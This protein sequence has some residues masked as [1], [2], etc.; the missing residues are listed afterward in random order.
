MSVFA[1]FATGTRK[2]TD[3]NKN[4]VRRNE[5]ADLVALV[6]CGQTMSPLHMLLHKL[7]DDES[8]IEHD[9]EQR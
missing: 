8:G 6:C 9:E 2:V 3:W 5:A 7:G 1:A 4:L